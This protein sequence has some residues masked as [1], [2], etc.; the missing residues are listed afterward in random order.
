M[1]VETE[2]RVSAKNSIG[3]GSTSEVVRLTSAALPNASSEIRVTEYGP[4]YLDLAWET[5]TDTGIY[6]QD[7][8]VT[9]EL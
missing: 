9:Y 6:N 5:P 3:Y 7:L 2:L 4:N 8:S 1:G